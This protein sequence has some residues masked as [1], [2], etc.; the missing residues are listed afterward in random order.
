MVG[1]KAINTKVMD[2][3]RRSMAI[4]TG[5]YESH[6]YSTSDFTLSEKRKKPAHGLSRRGL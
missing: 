5:S 2:V 4:C 6:R 3:K 1:E